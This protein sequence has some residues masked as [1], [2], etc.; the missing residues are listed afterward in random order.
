M[1]VFNPFPPFHMAGIMWSLPIICY[2]DST[3]VFSPVAPLTADLVN[4]VHECAGIEYSSLP[5]SVLTELAKNETYLQNL[6]CLRN[7]NF[8]GG[9]LSQAIGD[10]VSKYTSIGT[11]YGST[12]MFAPPL[13]PKKP[14][15][16][17]WHC[18]NTEQSGIE[19]REED[20]GLHELV[21]VRDD[22]LALTQ[23]I[24]VTFPDLQ[25][26]HTK[27][28]FSKH[29][30][31]P[32]LWKYEGRLDDIIVFSSGEKIN[33]VSMEGVIGSCPEVTGALVVGQGKFQTALLVEVKSPPT[34][35]AE[36]QQLKDSIWPFVQKANAASIAHAKISKDLILFAS[37]QKPL[38]RAGKGTVQR[39][40]GVKMYAEEIEEL[41]RNFESGEQPQLAQL[42][43]HN[44]E[45]AKASLREYLVNET[46]LKHIGSSEDLFGVGMDSI[47][48]ISLVH[49]VN[50]SLPDRDIEPRQVY[51]HPSIGKLAVSLQAPV[52]PIRDD[53]DDMETWTQMQQLFRDVTSNL[54]QQ[55]RAT[56]ATMGLESDRSSEY[57]SNEK[58]ASQ[59]SGA[60]FNA[61]DNGMRSW[62]RMLIPFGPTSKNLTRQPYIAADDE[63]FLIS[64][65]PP[66]GGATAWLQVLASFLINLN[67]WGLVNSF[68]VFQ[69]YYETNLL[70]SHSAATIAWIGTIQGAL[71]LIIGVFS[72]PLFDKGYFRVILVGAGIT[73]VFALM[74]LS[75]ATKYYQVMLSQGILIG[76]CCGLLYIPSVALMPLYFKDR[77]G[78]ALGLATSGASIGGII[79]PIAFRR[80]LNELGFPWAVRIIGFIALATLTA[81]AMVTRPLNGMT[82]PV[83]QLFD[84]SAFK[85][86][87]FLTFMI[88]A[89]LLFCGFL[90]PFFLTPIYA[91]TALHTS[92]NTAFYLLAV[93]NA[94][95]FFGRTIP[96]FLSDY[97]G[98]EIMMFCAEVVAGMLGLCWI[99]VHNLGGFTV[100]L[101]FY[102]FASGMLATL[103]AV[104]IPYLC[105]SLAVIGTRLGMIYAFAGVGALVS[106]PVATAAAADTG[107][108][109]GAQLW[110]G[111][112]ILT[113]SAFYLPAGIA[114]WRQRRAIDRPFGWK[115]KSME[116]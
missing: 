17:S 107:G 3:I 43:L 29:P 58:K 67:N 92:E 77:R 55:G 72:G 24:F 114:A 69:A 53:D 5:P 52:A 56:A 105:P 74:M 19:F 96:A 104:V 84:V 94:A 85:E 61:S 86:M 12:E 35:E 81:A 89:F 15:H 79:Y 80:L 110:M 1:R 8:A 51:E 45:A 59:F 82:K 42:D 21:I 20:S 116:S 95:Q 109:L 14:E 99:A 23:A 108:F 111:L 64:M 49:A 13:L 88:A 71:L 7:V 34:S 70:S 47:Q 65:M 103:P 26:Y 44:V 28:L 40:R 25:V 31:E 30:T 37:S 50:A 98:G 90:V 91:A 83:R 63:E 76:L 22:R 41:Y 39:A 48:I 10:L 101:I 57:P 32:A 36:K 113:A 68:G 66:D 78:L 75:L 93:I 2:I 46:G 87:P 4:A 60:S 16:W 27:D 54:P 6:S 102:G 38:P 33:P 97:F 106:V 62:A 18:F 11:S 9:P 115:G 112:C 73:L 100:F